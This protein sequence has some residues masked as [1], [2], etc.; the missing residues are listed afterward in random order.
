MLQNVHCNIDMYSNSTDNK[1]KI[2]QSIHKQEIINI[3]L[4]YIIIRKYYI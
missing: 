2:K 1:C 4:R 3:L